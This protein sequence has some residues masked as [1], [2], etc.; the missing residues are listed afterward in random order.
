MGILNSWDDVGEEN[1]NL[2]AEISM[3]KCANV[4]RMHIILSS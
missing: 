4:V 2:A 3:T 1:K